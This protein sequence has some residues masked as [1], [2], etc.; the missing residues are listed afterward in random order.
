[1]HSLLVAAGKQRTERARGASCNRRCSTP[2]WAWCG[3]GVGLSALG[4]GPG[5]AMWASNP[6]EPL[7]RGFQQRPP[8]S[9]RPA[10]SSAPLSTRQMPRPAVQPRREL[11][12]RP[13]RSFNSVEQV[14][15]QIITI[16][17]LEVDDADGDAALRKTQC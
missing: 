4:V 17:S 6:R 3:P 5:W 11:L 9:N 10:A 13:T 7:P 12:L 14:Q 16:S 2:V 1:M 15:Q 8:S